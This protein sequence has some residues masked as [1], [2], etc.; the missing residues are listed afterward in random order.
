M[1]EIYEQTIKKLFKND[2]CTKMAGSKNNPYP[3]IKNA[4]YLIQLSDHESWC[5][6]ITEAKKLGIPCIVTDFESSKEQIT[7]DE[8]GIIISLKDDTFYKYFEMILNNNQ[9]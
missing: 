3:Y 5:L 9:K 1:V 8:N 7:N 6:V 2:N 4:D